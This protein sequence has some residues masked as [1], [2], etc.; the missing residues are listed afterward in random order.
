M[1]PG[2]IGIDDLADGVGYV[3]AGKA[4]TE[5][6]ANRGALGGR[7]AERD[8]VIFLALLIEAQDADVADMVVAA[9]ID[10]TGDIDLERPDLVLARD[11]GEL[12]R[13]GLGH[14]NRAGRGE[15]A[16]VHAGAGD[17]V[18]GQA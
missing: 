17:D 8:L 4:R 18:A 7:A 16:V 15:R 3:L 11:V 12:A 10:A 6:R 14:G 1:A 13:D 2:D 9:G 5:D